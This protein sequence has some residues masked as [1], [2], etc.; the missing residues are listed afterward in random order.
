MSDVSTAGNAVATSAVLGIGQV[1]LPGRSL[2]SP[3]GRYRLTFQTDAKLVLYNAGGP[4]WSSGNASGGGKAGACVIDT[5]GKLAIY[6]PGMHRLWCSDDRAEGA[7]PTTRLVVQ[8]DG[9]VVIYDRFEGVRFATDTAIPAAFPAQGSVMGTSSGL[10]PG[11]SL[12][13]A[14]GRYRFVYQTDGNLVL[15]GPGGA[16]WDQ[17]TGGTPAGVCL[18][19]GDGDLIIHRPPAPYVHVSNTPENKGA[20]LVVQDDANVVLYGV[21]RVAVEWETG[22]TLPFGPDVGT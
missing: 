4:L 14:N 1:L 21:D 10:Y 17:G 9:N 2:V 3:N 5:H 7:D 22:T 18:L 6:A 16:L 11:D 20:Q 13:S 15:Y 8:D 12:W 19:T